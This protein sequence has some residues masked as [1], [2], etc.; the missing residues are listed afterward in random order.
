MFDLSETDGDL[1][2]TVRVIPRASRSEIIG[3]YAGALKI[4]ISSA[5][6]DGAA[7]KELT[8]I[9]SK[10]FGVSKSRIEIIS[11]ETA[12]MK[13]IKICKM[14]SKRFLEIIGD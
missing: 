6:V 14:N 9:L 11:G 12:R 10:K 8:K 3:E 7:N 1:I 4:K 5:P 13:S 2:F